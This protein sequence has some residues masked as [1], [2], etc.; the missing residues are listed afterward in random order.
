MGNV[1]GYQVK[2]RQGVGGEVYITN[3]KCHREMGDWRVIRQE[4]NESVG[5]WIV[6]DWLTL[7]IVE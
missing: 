2:V 6:C 4:E 7:R 3:K 1:G 5:G